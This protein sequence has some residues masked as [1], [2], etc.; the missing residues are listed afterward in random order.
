MIIPIAT[1][2]V[3]PADLAQVFS[4]E[5]KAAAGLAGASGDSKN[6]DGSQSQGSLVHF[7]DQTLGLVHIFR[8]DD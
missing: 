4:P 5:T 8:M 3:T 2:Q 7:H 6:P 1:A